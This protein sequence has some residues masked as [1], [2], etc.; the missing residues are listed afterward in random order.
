MAEVFEPEA[1][2][3]AGDGIQTRDIQ[4]RK[5]VDARFASR[6]AFPAA[7]VWFCFRLSEYDDGLPSH[8]ITPEGE[9][10]WTIPARTT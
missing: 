7:H 9:A 8:G 4:A 2:F 10:Q 3:G 5:V 1:S 6:K